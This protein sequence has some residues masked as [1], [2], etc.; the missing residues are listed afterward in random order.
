MI[1]HL[2]LGLALALTTATAASA[3]TPQP[4]RGGTLNF[5][6]VSDPPNYDCHAHETYVV[7]QSVGPFYS[8]LLK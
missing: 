3:Q 2:A 1:R 7:V 6:V 5:A 4:A 8:T